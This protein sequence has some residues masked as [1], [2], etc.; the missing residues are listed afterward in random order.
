T[1]LKSL[2]PNIAPCFFQRTVLPLLGPSLPRRS[3][4]PSPRSLPQALR[5][6]KLSATLSRL[7]PAPY[8]RDGRIHHHPGYPQFPFRTLQTPPR[9]P[10]SARRA[11]VLAYIANLLL[12]TIPTV[13]SELASSPSDEP[14]KVDVNLGHLP[15]PNR[16]PQPTN[17]ETFLTS[18]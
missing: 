8:P 17:H 14:V 9:R 11:A 18:R 12:R 15:S 10:H 5:H 13:H 3:S 6:P 2:L 1:T 16:D 4:Q 7:P